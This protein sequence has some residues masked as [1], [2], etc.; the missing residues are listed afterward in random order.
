[1]IEAARK[2]NCIIQVGTQNR[3]APY[4]MAA[5]E[6]I[7]SG[8]LGDIRLVKVFNLKKSSSLRLGKAESKP[9]NFDWDAWLGPAPQRPYH[10]NIFHGGWHHFWD[11][12]GGDLAD[13]AAHQ[14]DLALMLMGD[15]GM[16]KA[17]SSSGGRLQHT[18]DSEVPDLLVTSEGSGAVLRTGDHEERHAVGLVA[19]RGVVDRHLLARR[20]VT[21][22]RTLGARRELVAKPHV[23]EGPPHHHLVVAAA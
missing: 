11:F 1:M 6:Y 21:R 16:P 12:S 23:R 9:K 15:P 10:Q 14:I 3:S 7:K 8:K 4:N 20:L 13:D 18:D 22:P 17:A 19:H 2:Y 5:R